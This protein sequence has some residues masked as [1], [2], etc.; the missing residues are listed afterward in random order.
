[1]TTETTTHSD[2]RFY[3][4]TVENQV[5]DH[6]KSALRKTLASDE[7]RMGLE[8]KVSTVKFVTESLVRHLIRLLDLE[9]ET[10]A[11]D[12]I[13]ENKP[14]LAEKTAALQFEHSQFRAVLQEMSDQARGISPD[15]EP[16]FDAF[17]RDV[18]A[19]LDRLDQHEARELAI[20]QELHNAEE[21]GEG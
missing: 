20:L 3:Q 6:V 17:C 8:R 15:N 12:P 11:A 4:F 18:L 13:A 1:M 7:D 5:L 9:D 19:F 14:H 2:A 16:H 10:E 21:G